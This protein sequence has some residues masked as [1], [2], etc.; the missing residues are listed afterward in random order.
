M[1][2]GISPHGSSV[3]SG[4]IDRPGRNGTN[5]RS[6]GTRWQMR[7]S[8]GQVIVLWSVI[9]G[10]MLMVFMF[11]LH[12][13]REQGLKQ[14]LEDH[15][16]DAV[17]L[18]IAQAVPP[19]ETGGT[20]A[21]AMNDAA[22]ASSATASGGG[23]DASPE[24]RAVAAPP[25]ADAA[26][27]VAESELLALEKPRSQAAAAGSAE[28][29]FTKPPA[30]ALGA[31]EARPAGR[32]LLDIFSNAGSRTARPAESGTEGSTGD[33][34]T[35]RAALMHP[36]EDASGSKPLAAIEE[37]KK[38]RSDRKDAKEAALKEKEQ[39]K[40]A[41]LAAQTAAARAAATKNAPV[42]TK[43]AAPERAKSAGRSGV[44]PGW[45]L[46]VAAAK[47]SDEA[48]GMMRKLQSA[49]LQPQLEEAVVGR[50]R[51][52]RVV[53]GPFPSK[54]AAA[55]RRASVRAVRAAVGEPFVRKID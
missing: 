42:A 11:G 33:G 24:S 35:A 46:Q 8:L 43:S 13:G 10:T 16:P 54:D 38:E 17:R 19:A 39:K 4:A 37:Q 34:T 50:N 1:T 22:R 45:Y 53:V 20:I 26:G 6:S 28:I 25:A 30:A 12:A 36:S 32:P 2:S 55:E 21:L 7:L 47:T 23:A 40:A 3:V 49:G 51:Y 41:R 18:P 48:K 44:R 29:D 31:S 27:R 52:Y 5:D 15:A 9:G 14:A